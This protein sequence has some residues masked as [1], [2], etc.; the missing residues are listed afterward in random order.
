[1]IFCSMS[2]VAARAAVPVV[3][4]S[5]QTAISNQ[6][7]AI[8][9]HSHADHTSTTRYSH[10][11]RASLART[12]HQLTNRTDWH[13]DHES[14]SSIRPGGHKISI[15]DCRESDGGPVDCIDESISGEEEV[16]SV[17]YTAGQSAITTPFLLRVL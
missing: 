13:V 17:G 6:Q 7:S 3:P 14:E 10:S 9:K 4:Y 12:T 16:W 5:E 2:T 15:A 11:T 1:M 8:T